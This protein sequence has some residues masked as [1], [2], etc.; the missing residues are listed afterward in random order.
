MVVQVTTFAT[1]RGHVLLSCLFLLAETSCVL[2][3]KSDG[4]YLMGTVLEITLCDQRG[5]T[6]LQAEQT[7]AKLFATITHLEALLSTFSPDSAVSFLNVHAGQGAYPAPPE[8]IELLTFSQRYW[9]L[10]HGTFDVTIGPLMHAWRL[11]GESQQAPSPAALQQVKTRIGSDK[12]KILPNAQVM[13]AR[14]GMAIDLG[15][16]GKGYALDQL[17]RTLK[18]QPRNS[19]LL[20]FGQSSLWA[21]GSPP[22]APRWRLLVQRP[23]GQPVGVIAL[24][25]QALSISASFAQTFVIQGRQY[26][27]VIDPRSGLPLQRD[28]LA[29][30]V[31]PNATQAEALSKALLILGER[32]G[33]ALL[34]QLP[35]TEGFLSEGDGRQWMTSGWRETTAFSPMP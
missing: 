2:A 28:L 15:G 21:L 23:S 35:G 20:D 9:R 13:L 12:V 34:E 14:P 25:N 24:S 26:G 33:I 3:C 4:R 8:V 19:A 6:S 16:I 18:S 22:D 11:A 10:T 1:W 17:A 32:A 7:F 5:E 29:C 30:V 31:A 27:H